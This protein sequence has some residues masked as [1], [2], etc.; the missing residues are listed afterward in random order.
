LKSYWQYICWLKNEIKGLGTSIAY[1]FVFGSV[2]KA[3]AKPNDCDLMIIT[4][5][6]PTDPVWAE[7]RSK[8]DI[9]CNRFYAKWNLELSVIL[10]TVDE[11]K[12]KNP[13]LKRILNRPFVNILGDSIKTQNN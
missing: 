4:H 5:A 3:S 8:R 1:A 2:A 9:L 13:F 11:Y 6:N 7:V 10:L 12:E